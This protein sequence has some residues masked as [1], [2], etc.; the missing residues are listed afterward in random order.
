MIPWKIIVIDEFLLTRNGKVDRKELPKPTISVSYKEASTCTE[1]YL[2]D[3]L[4][5]VLNI[6]HNELDSVSYRRLPLVATLA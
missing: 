2:V 1:L 4:Q 6:D 5:E 3:L